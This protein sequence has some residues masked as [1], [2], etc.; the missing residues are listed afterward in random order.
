MARTTTK[1]KSPKKKPKS[2]QNIRPKRITRSAARSEAANTLTKLIALNNL[3]KISL[4]TINQPG[5]TSHSN[6][7]NHVDP[8][9][10]YFTT[11]KED[12]PNNTLSY[13]RGTSSFSDNEII[14]IPDESF[15]ERADQNATKKNTTSSNLLDSPV[16]DIE[17]IEILDTQVFSNKP[18]EVIVL[19]DTSDEECTSDATPIAQQPRLREIEKPPI[20]RR[21]IHERLGSLINPSKPNIKPYQSPL[22]HIKKPIGGNNDRSAIFLSD[23]N[24][25][26]NDPSG[27]HTKLQS[28]WQPLL[29]QVNTVSTSNRKLRP[30]I[31]DGLNIG[32]S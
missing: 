15:P 28:Q 10:F 20:T 6:S 2:N 21:P 22:R 29:P 1:K 14:E 24:I 12:F 17:V 19:S 27:N 30:I 31:I 4:E 25:A 13:S 16:D 18:I 8:K 23:N 5:M 3:P 7:S 9:N 26:V 11:K 32:F